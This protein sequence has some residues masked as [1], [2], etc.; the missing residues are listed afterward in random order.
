LRRAGPARQRLEKLA[1][2]RGGIARRR[3]GR[4]RR[5]DIGG[6]SRPATYASGSGTNALVFTYAVAAGVND[7]DGIAVGI[8]AFSLNFNK[9]D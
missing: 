7:A 8:N 1:E 5:G 4:R 2:Q 9:C 6:V 3:I